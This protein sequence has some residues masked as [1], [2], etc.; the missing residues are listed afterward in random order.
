MCPSDAKKCFKC[1]KIKPLS[2]FYPHPQMA[3]KHLNKCKECAR[4]DTRDNLKKRWK[5]YRNYDWARHHTNKERFLAHK[6]LGMKARAL[7]KGGH[8]TG[9][10]GK[11]FLT[12]EEWQEWCEATSLVFDNLWEQWKKSGFERRFTPSVDRIDNSKGY[13]KDNLQWMTMEKNLQKYI[14]EETQKRGQ[15]VILKNDLEVARVWTQQEAAEFI[16][17]DKSKVSAILRGKGKTT[18]GYAFR[19]DKEQ[20]QEL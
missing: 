20:G 4:K 10:T 5:Q 13:E 12:K 18:K 8:P 9:A 1:G 3:D 2:E 14:A 11:P 17:G 16:G 6:Y 15:I 19:Y 7:G